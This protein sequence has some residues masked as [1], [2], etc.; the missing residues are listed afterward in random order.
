MKKIN[1]MIDIL[2]NKGLII[3]DGMEVKRLKSGTTNGVLYTLLF[4]EIPTYVIK[5]D[6]PKISI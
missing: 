4:Y 6:T 3:H 2:V 5:I 1:E